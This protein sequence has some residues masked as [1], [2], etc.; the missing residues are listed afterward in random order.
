[1]KKCKKK[2]G[3]M[4]FFLLTRSLAGGGYGHGE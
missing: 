1:M 4:L 2:R 3:R